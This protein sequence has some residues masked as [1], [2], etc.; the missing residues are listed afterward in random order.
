M[1]ITSF[2]SFNEIRIKNISNTHLLTWSQF[3]IPAHGKS[4]RITVSQNS[5]LV[6]I[7]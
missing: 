5:T 3:T 4:D 1:D 2:Y 7:Y 6:H